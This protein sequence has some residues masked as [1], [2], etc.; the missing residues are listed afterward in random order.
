M[1][2]AQD[3]QSRQGS[4]LFKIVLISKLEA[5][6]LNTNLNADFLSSAS[7]HEKCVRSVCVC[8]CVCVFEC[9]KPVWL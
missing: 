9:R 8:V 5:F 6:N 2:K 3:R 4:A 1:E 7:K